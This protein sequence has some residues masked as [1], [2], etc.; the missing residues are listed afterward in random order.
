M[1]ADIKWFGHSGFKI[2]SQGKVIY[3]DPFKLSSSEPADLILITHEHYDHCSG[4]D[5]A[6]IQRDDTQI[7]AAQE[8]KPKLKGDVRLVK[9]GDNLE[10]RGIKIEVVPAYNI[11]KDFHPKED[12]K[13]GFVLDLEGER[14]Y[15]AGDTDLIPEM[16]NIKCDIAILPVSGTY[17]MTA[18]EAAQAADILN[19]K[20]AIPMHYGEIVGS[21]SDAQRFKELAKCAVKI[22]EKQ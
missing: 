16:N 13:V 17:V 1:S 21:L 5:I 18:E 22:L 4:D 19:P 6:K 8:C 10:V 3:I 15:H 20:V 14:I 9:P 12:N 11:G 7:V 2:L